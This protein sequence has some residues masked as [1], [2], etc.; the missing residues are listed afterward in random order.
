MSSAATAGVDCRIIPSSICTNARQTELM[1]REV[2]LRAKMLGPP[3]LLQFPWYL[4]PLHVPDGPVSTVLPA[5]PTPPASKA[6]VMIPGF[7]LFTLQSKQP[8]CISIRPPSAVGIR[9]STIV[10]RVSCRVTYERLLMLTTEQRRSLVL[11]QCFSSSFFS[12]IC[13]SFSGFQVPACLISKL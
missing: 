7:P 9:G 2:L 1:Y 8:L 10:R 12:P 6:Q 11:N 4:G 13:R 5:T 3:E